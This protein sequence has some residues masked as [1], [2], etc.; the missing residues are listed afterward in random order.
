MVKKKLIG[1]I[2]AGGTKF[3]C[4]VADETMKIYDRR[5]FPTNFPDET[6][7]KVFDF[8]DGYNVEAIGVGSFGPI[9]INEDSEYFGYITSTPKKGWDYFN[10]VGALKNRY[11]VP[12]YWTTDVNAAAYGEYNFGIAKTAKSCVYFTIGTGV[13]AGAIQNDQFIGGISHSEMGHMIVSPHR[14]EKISSLCKFHDNC[15]EGFASGPT[16]EKRT[17][18]IGENVDS[19]DPNWD[20]VAYYIAQAI[21]NTTLFL[22]PEIIILG[23]GVMKK[24]GLLDKVKKEFT[25][26]L[27]SYVIIP[28]IE[29]YIVSPSLNDNQAIMGCIKL[30]LDKI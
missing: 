20:I 30:V 11:D 16:L 25:N 21:H 22:A 3:V 1:A 4:A 19:D 6:M 14:N 8:F 9:D 7:E 15:L 26:M 29:D 24:K 13:G 18:I 28:D 5:S 2:E 17:G 23:G 12:I 10:F 27:N